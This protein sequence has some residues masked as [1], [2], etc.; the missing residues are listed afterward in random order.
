LQLATWNVNS[1]RVRLPQLLGW[2]ERNPVDI[3]AL[4]ELK[5]TDD[6]FPRAELEQAGWHALCNGQKT[7]NGVAILSR[8]A[9]AADIVRDIPGF[10]DTQRRVLAATYG[11]LRFISV[12]VPNGQRLGSDQYSYKLRWLEALR[13][14]LADELRRHSQLIVLGDYNVA[15]EDRDVHDP[16]LW[17]NSIHVSVP[18]RAALRAL[19]DLG[20]EDLF[21]RFEQPPACFSWWDYRAGAFRR[22]RGL[23]IDLMLA[24]Q[25]LAERCTAASI[26]REPRGWERPTDHAPVLASFTAPP[27]MSNPTRP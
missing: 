15:P 8:D 5:L 20:L 13:T 4:Q 25:A 6:E 22:N 1:L 27:L 16:V 21:R 19:L 17:A 3:I 23:R 9:T 10:E 18:E 2:L 11:D 7:Y 24:S 12:Y 14:W 26:D